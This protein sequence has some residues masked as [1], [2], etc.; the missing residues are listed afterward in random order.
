VTIDCDVS[1]PY[2]LV[3][4]LLGQFVPRPIRTTA[5]E[6]AIGELDS[7]DVQF[8][9]EVDRVPWVRFCQCAHARKIPEVGVSVAVVSKV[10]T[11]CAKTH[12]VRTA[13]VRRTVQCHIDVQASV[14]RHCN[15]H[16]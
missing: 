15:A 5:E 4:P 14:R 16:R 2:E 11:E 9:P 13:L 10:W 8:H 7:S 6:G 1:S 12:D 3:T